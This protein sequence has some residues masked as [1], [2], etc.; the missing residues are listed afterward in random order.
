LLAYGDNTTE[1]PAGM[2][3]KGSAG[4][5]TAAGP[6]AAM[7]AAITAVPLEH[8]RLM[9]AC[10]GAGAGH[11]LITRPDELSARTN[12]YPSL[13]PHKLV[14]LEPPRTPVRRAAAVRRLMF[15]PHRM[16]TVRLSRS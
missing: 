14:A 12:H 3:G 7:D 15:P 13:E 8:R 11:G 10:D 5:D 2:P 4:P 9:A 1:A 16:E 6:L